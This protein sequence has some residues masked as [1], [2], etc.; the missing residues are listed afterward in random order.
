MPI[1]AAAPPV[2]L[3]PAC[4]T[5]RNRDSLAMD[6]RRSRCVEPAARCR[7][8]RERRE[9]FPSPGT[10]VRVE[11][12]GS[13]KVGRRTALCQASLEVTSHIAFEYSDPRFLGFD[14]VMP[15]E[16]SNDAAANR[17]LGGDGEWLRRS[18]A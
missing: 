5:V 3:E 4:E 11:R 17:W 16:R 12:Q 15:D 9:P 10:Q 14:A 18:S 8:Y 6:R 1:C 13:G 2:Q 7:D